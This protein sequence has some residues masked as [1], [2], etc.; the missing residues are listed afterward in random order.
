[1]IKVV[2]IN[3]IIVPCASNMFTP[4]NCPA[5]VRLDKDMATA[6]HNGIPESTVVNPN[7]M[8]TEK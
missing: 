5:L 1:M 8:D 4:A 3:S 6:D 2:M 7:A